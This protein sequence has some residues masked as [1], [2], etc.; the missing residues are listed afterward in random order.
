MTVVFTVVV[1]PTVAV[2][3]CVY[4]PDFR[5]L[6]HNKS[7]SEVWPT[8]ESKPHSETKLVSK[9]MV[10]HTKSSKRRHTIPIGI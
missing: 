2:A 1:D 8:N 4:V 5:M 3:V 6:L 10:F 9:H 7:A